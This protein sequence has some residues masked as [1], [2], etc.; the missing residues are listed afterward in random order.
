MA[1]QNTSKNQQFLQQL[2]RQ[3]LNKPCNRIIDLRGKVAGECQAYTFGG[4]THYL[5]DRA[6][7]LA[8]Q[9]L[10]HFNGRYTFGVYEAVLKALK[11]LSLKS[12]IHHDN[13]TGQTES[14]VKLLPF[15]S[16]LQRKEPRIIFATPVEIRIADMLYHATTINITSSAISV[17]LKRCYT[18]DKGDEVTA[19]LL[20]L[21]SEDNSSLLSKIAY[22][23]LKIDHNDLHTQLILVRNRHD[24]NEVS[25][26]LDRWSQEHSSAEYLDI[27]NE[28]FNL[29]THYFLRLYHR[30]L[31]SALF[32]LNSQDQAKPIKA[33]QM[34]DLAEKIFK[35]H[36]FEDKFDL[37]LL[38][39]QQVITEQCDFLLLLSSDNNIHRRY[40]A[41]RDNNEQVAHLLNW[42]SQQ[43]NSRV[44]LLQTNNTAIDQVH[45]EAE[46]N[47]IENTDIDY[48]AKLKQRL[49]DISS[50]IT[51]S[52][53]SNSCQHLGQAEHKD[54]PEAFTTQWAGE[55]TLPLTLRHH[56]QRDDKRFFIKTNV[57]LHTSKDKKT[58]DVTTTDVSNNGASL[59]LIGRVNLTV[60]TPVKIDFVRWQSQ[61][62]KVNLS[63][64]P[65]IVKS[66]KFSDG[67][68][69]IGLER[70]IAVCSR[71]VNKF[72]IRTLENNKEQLVENNL[73]IF[74]SQETKIFSALLA[75]EQT[76]IPF[77]LSLDKD[78]QRRLQAVATS[79]QNQAH[80]PQLWS[81]L[82]EHVVAMSQLLTELPARPDSSASFGLYCYLD[83]AGQWKIQADYA[84]TSAA[85]KS[86]F[87]NQAKRYEHY[88]FY[89]CTLTPINAHLV[90]QESD[91]MQK[92]VQLRSYKP[93]KVKQARDALH[94]LFAVGELIDITDIIKANYCH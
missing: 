87:I 40:L 59:D 46:I 76:T 39:F 13:I 24:N 81:A 35:S 20:T 8:K 91:L 21:A 86:L 73:D 12:N 37:S 50:A 57:H 66:N 78:N 94:S 88:H 82:Q 10:D 67:I 49:A 84:F 9:L 18:L 29:T 19:S 33:F 41:R 30:T 70:D 31:N 47:T 85:Q 77:F 92:L 83:H 45:F 6:Y 32:W 3:R 34:T 4:K 58:Y 51:V 54:E 27:D 52:D 55:Q 61:T 28:L 68:S 11:S 89:H 64:L 79:E 15:D 60:G 5:D 44:L 53:I 62:K 56:I 7:L 69:H 43:K 23:I 65:F 90:E 2:E 26:W 75:Q 71:E 80:K 48:A 42:H 16:Q 36:Q 22:S 1:E 72:F 63:K 25:Q 74:T 38:P 93:H 17:S 14:E